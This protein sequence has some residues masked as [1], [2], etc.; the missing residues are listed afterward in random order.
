[1]RLRTQILMFLLLFG[2]GPLLATLLSTAPLVV[3][4][5]E[6]FYHKAHLQNLRADFRDLDQH[7]ASRV[8][9][10][11]LLAKL[12]EGEML[13]ADPGPTKNP[14][15]LRLEEHYADAV[16]RILF[17]QQDIVQ[18]L[19]LAPDGTPRFWLGREGE[20]LRLGV[21]PALLDLPELGF[22][23]AG[24]KL[25]SGG[26]LTSP[27][28]VNPIAGARDPTRFM[29][30][31]L[32]SPLTSLHHPSDSEPGL[33]PA[34]GAVVINID[35]GGLAE[36]YPKTYWVLSDGSFL[37]YGGTQGPE[38]AAFQQFPGL[39]EIIR[40]GEVALWK[41]ADQQQI[42]WLPLLATERSG[43][44]W[45]GRQ[46]DASPLSQFLGALETRA[47]LIVLPLIVLILILAHWLAG[48]AERFGRELTDGI[49]RLL[50]GGQPVRFD[51]NGPRE[52]RELSANLSRLA[53]AHAANSQALR[54]H[55]RELEESNRYKS[56]FL[57]NVSHELR[58]P[59]NSILLLS[60][61]LAESTATGMSAEQA[62]QARVI[63]DAGRDLAGLI[64]NILDLARIEAR[65]AVMHIEPVEI[66][67]LL[68][69]LVD[70]IRPQTETRGIGLDLQ[71]EADAPRVA[72]TDGDKV[73]QI[74]KNF[75]SNAVKFTDRGQ[76]RVR[77]T[78][79][80]AADGTDR[81]VRI[82]V[83]D[84]G[85]GI[86]AD[87]HEV[88]F[89]AFRQADGSTSRRYGGSG[90]GLAISRG[91][92]GM[93]G[94][95]IDVTS[96]PGE[97]STF[98]L[99]LP[100]EAS[101]DAEGGEGPRRPARPEPGAPAPLPHADFAGQRV[102]VV[103]GDVRDLLALTPLLERWGLQVAAAGD[104]DEAFEVLHDEEPVDLVLIDGM[105]P[106]PGSDDTIRRIRADER[107]R[108]LPVVALTART[109]EAVRARTLEAGAQEVVQKPLD[110]LELRDALARHLQPGKPD[111]ASPTHRA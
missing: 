85:I 6:L 29:V 95:R 76:V 40:K 37:R 88:I 91:L 100:L 82:E 93:L 56:E 86:P 54:E 65:R 26:V 67:P 84:T 51:W 58:T 41:G 110:P 61:L 66:E 98:S 62:R 89:E 31:R 24:M 18:V 30:L 71:V 104:G 22:F 60:K 38:A 12:P 17:D 102:L 87:K 75:L 78:R 59:L 11:R 21:D 64:D 25:D 7:I 13:V 39:E 79:N 3:T 109:E 15:R 44:L 48:R 36:A 72:V 5:L 105:L 55:A 50:H 47:G 42:L 103:A 73:R 94:G 80:K 49:A 63:R 107:F 19:F 106:G 1:M 2:L 97:G 52:V 10:V 27:V 28:S 4:S 70:L 34:P 81:P 14:A 92:A 35:V 53:E 101:G 90:L 83:S 23:E 46:V 43:P 108:R 69:G 33:L 32:I 68:V 111:R 8:E 20:R 9:M 74:L 96:R 16:N 45:V 77:L 99:L 57:A